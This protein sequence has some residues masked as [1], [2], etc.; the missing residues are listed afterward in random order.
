MDRTTGKPK[1]FTDLRSATSKTIGSDKVQLIVETVRKNL[2]TRMGEHYTG[3]PPNTAHFRCTIPNF[4]Y[5]G[6]LFRILGSFFVFWTV[7]WE[8]CRINFWNQGMR[9]ILKYGIGKYWLIW[10]FAD[11][12]ILKYRETENTNWFDIFL[13]WSTQSCTKRGRAN[14]SAQKGDLAVL[15]KRDRPI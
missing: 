2:V 11:H 6:L 12:R 1:F 15:K 8:L 4:P 3:E 9:A 10:Y 5:L 7:F 14:K 13:D